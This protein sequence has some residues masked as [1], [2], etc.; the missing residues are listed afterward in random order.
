VNL[1]VMSAVQTVKQM[2]DNREIKIEQDLVSEL[3]SV[4]ADGNRLQQVF[5][6]LLSNSIKF[7]R[8]G[9]SIRIRT[10]N[11]N[12]VIEVR[13]EDNGIGI[14]PSFLPLV[15]ERFR[16]ADSSSTRRYGGL[17]I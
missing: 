3:P 10:L 13:V 6:N 16:Q 5:W 7:S 11:L 14:D 15:F 4:N 1:A 8:R 9:G 12:N 17:G 2:A